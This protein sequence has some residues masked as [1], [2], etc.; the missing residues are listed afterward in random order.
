MV[1]TRIISSPSPYIS[2]PRFLDSLDPEDEKHG[3]GRVRYPRFLVQEQVVHV[4][5]IIE[6][7][8]LLIPTSHHSV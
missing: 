7:E 8:P 1:K 6:Q 5:K 2:S 4:P 3:G